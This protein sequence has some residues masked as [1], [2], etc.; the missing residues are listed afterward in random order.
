MTLPRPAFHGAVLYPGTTPRPYNEREA[1]EREL[2]EEL[3]PQL[4]G[5]Q[6]ELAAGQADNTRRDFLEWHTRRVRKRMAELEARLA[7]AVDGS[8]G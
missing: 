3:P 6:Q 2:R 8:R 1:W 5:Y 7:K 4:A